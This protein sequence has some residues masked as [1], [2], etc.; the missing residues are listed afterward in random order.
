[1]TPKP[2]EPNA[3]EALLIKALRS[4]KYKQTRGQLRY[5]NTFCCLGVACDLWGPEEWRGYN[6][7]GYDYES[8]RL[9]KPVMEWLGW[10]DPEG[11]ILFMQKDGLGLMHSRLT[12]LNDDGLTFD[13]IADI[14][15]AGLVD[16]VGE[17]QP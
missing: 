16:S 3:A 10:T 4:G 2:Y 14:I 12:T 5:D 8:T 1:M 17:P 6:G 13:Q 7:F 9:T 11:L 15:Q